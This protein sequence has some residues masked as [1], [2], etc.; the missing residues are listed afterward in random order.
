[1]EPTPPRKLL[2]QVRDALRRQWRQYVLPSE[3]IS[4]DPRIEMVL[5]QNLDESSL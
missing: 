3:H 1:M 5:S 4:K 2:D